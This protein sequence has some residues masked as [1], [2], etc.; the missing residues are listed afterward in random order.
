MFGQGAPKLKC[1]SCH[2]EI[3]D[4]VARRRGYHGRSFDAKKGDVDC[5]RCHTEHYGKNFRIIHWPESKDDFD[6]RTAGYPLEGRHARLKCE[7]CHNPRHISAAARKLIAVKDLTRTFMGLSTACLTCHEDHHAGQ[8]S[9]DCQRCHGYS[10]WKPLVSFD[11]SKSHFPLTGKHVDVQCEKCHR[12]LPDNEK[13]IQYTGLKFAECSGCHRD[14]HNGAFAARCESCHNTNAW[15]ATGV[16][17]AFNHDSTKFPLTGKHVGLACEKCHKTANFK[18]PIAHAKCMDCHEDQHKGQFVT[19]ADHGEC[20]SCH[21]DKGFRPTTFTEASHQATAFPLLAKH[22]GV[23]CAKC[24]PGTGLGI[25]YHPAYKL[26][27]DCHRDPHGRQFATAP[28]QNRCQDCHTVEGFQPSTFTLSRH[29]SSRFD[30][31][32]AHAA[33]ACLDCHRTDNKPEG[34][35]RRFHFVALA[36]TTCHQDPHHGEF[37]AVMTVALKPGHEVCETCHELRSWRKLKTFD[38]SITTFTL[39]GVHATLGCVDCHRPRAV[40]AGA[41]AIPFKSAP[42]RCAGCHEDIHAGQFDR[43]SGPAECSACHVQT[44][45]IAARFDHDHNTSF[46]LS[47]AHANVPCRL[48]HLSREGTA[49]RKV[50]VYKDT[51]RECQSCHR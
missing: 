39:D 32:G 30:L 40:E 24:H 49:G 9:T 2:A 1:Q 16:S 36:C 26:C 27:A 13:V 21:V 48:C 38:H 33:V 46:S 47:G 7:E 17:T 10:Q 29:Q 12:P 37:P 43:P 51:P 14:P 5:A 34:A 8:L 6:H 3:R 22:S 25:N 15:R 11:H 45:W 42:E 18:T 28:Y 44:R 23:A 20:G 50:V 35:D 4:L 41:R 19:R 31:K